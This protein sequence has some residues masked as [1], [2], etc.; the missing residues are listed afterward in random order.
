M[1]V[2]ATWKKGIDNIP[3]EPVVLPESISWTPKVPM[4]EVKRL[5]Q[6]V[7]NRKDPTPYQLDLM[8]YQQT[9]T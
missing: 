6:A 5:K 7:K 9:C 2:L 3:G 4:A 8:R 1:A